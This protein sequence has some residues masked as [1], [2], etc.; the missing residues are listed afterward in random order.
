MRWLRRYASKNG[1]Q[2]FIRVRMR[3][4]FETEIPV[5]DYVNNSKVQ[6]SVK[7]EHWNKGHVTGGRYHIP[8]RDLNNLLT[9]VEAD[10]KDAVNMALQGKV[11]IN[12]EN[13]IRLTYI[14]ELTAEENE[15]KI[16]TG[17]VIVDEQG[18]A[19]ASQEEFEEFI[20]TT[21]DPK[22]DKLKKILGVY[23]NEYILDY[24]DG[25]IKNFAP[26]SYNSPYNSIEGY[27]KETGNNCKAS[28]FSDLWL[29]QFFKHI[30]EN[31]YSFR[32]DGTN[33][34]PYLIS[35]INKYNKHLRH[36]GDYLFNEIKVLDN[37]NYRR[38]KL[39]E[40]VKKK[41]L[42]KYDSEQYI[43]N[44]ALY[45]KEF[46][47]FYGFYFDDKRFET[48]RDM[49]VLQVW[50][51][52]LRQVDF[53][54]LSKINFHKDSYGKYRVWFEQEKTEGNVLNVANQN[55]LI[56]ILETASRRHRLRFRSP[57]HADGRDG[58]HP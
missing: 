29:Q 5:Y 13:L 30:I 12:R 25:F 18:G 56:P 28:E 10:V 24:W 19:F 31:G 47:Y 8:V 54:N 41:S 21:H 45:K 4:G 20:E 36:F 16:A 27:I 7:K 53:Y 11:P 9:K 43:N 37:Q 39:K 6:I 26:D 44:H 14:N 48:V 22:F 55:Y 32:K 3:N 2:V 51:G 40:K 50:L 57:D 46:D 17:E 33:R 34:Q 35:T 49:F 42:I 52:G 58:V 1:Q 15:R 38:F 23:S